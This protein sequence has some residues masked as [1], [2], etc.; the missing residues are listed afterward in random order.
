MRKVFISVSVI[1]FL[2][3]IILIGVAKEQS[4]PTV[5]KAITR[6]GRTI[7]NIL[8]EEDFRLYKFIIFTNKDND[9]CAA[10]IDKTLWGFKFGNWGGG[11]FNIKYAINCAYLPKYKGVPF[12]IMWGKVY[13]NNISKIRLI[14][15]DENKEYNAKIINTNYGRI[16]FAFLN[17]TKSER[18]K[19]LGL[20]SGQKT[21]YESYMDIN[22]KTGSKVGT[23]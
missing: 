23:K 10:F 14:D 2:L 8:Y 1:L 16:C 17:E 20:D 11:T 22:F 12:P 13:D 5:S 9:I 4:S 19:V 18:L 6:T 7:S 15:E 21:V 3:L